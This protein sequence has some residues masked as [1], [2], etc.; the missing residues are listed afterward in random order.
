MFF[1]TFL[2]APIDGHDGLFLNSSINGS[3][4]CMT[5]FLRYHLDTKPRHMTSFFFVR[6]SKETLGVHKKNMQTT[7]TQGGF[8]KNE[9][10]KTLKSSWLEGG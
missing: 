5:H 6:E 9:A 1:F 8:R 4:S 7:K 10:A 2:D 3:N